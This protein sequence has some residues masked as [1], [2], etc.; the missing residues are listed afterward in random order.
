MLYLRSLGVLVLE[1][2]LVLGFGGH[3]A[4]ADLHSEAKAG[5]LEGVRKALEAGANPNELPEKT[6]AALHAAAL[7]GHKQIA[8][9][10]IEHGAK[11][12]LRQFGVIPLNLAVDRGDVALVTV[13]LKAGS[14]VES[15]DNTSAHPLHKASEMGNRPLVEILLA[16]GAALEAM[17]RYGRSPLAVAVSEG[18]VLVVRLLLARKANVD[19]PLK[20]GRRPLHISLRKGHA[21]ITPLLLE[22]GAKQDVL[23]AAALGDTLLLDALLT[24]GA[25]IEQPMPW[26]GT[27]PLMWA[28]RAGQAKTVQHLLAKG[29]RKNTRDKRSFTALHYAASSG[30]VNTARVLLDAGCETDAKGRF[31]STPLIEASQAGHGPMIALLFSR[32]ADVNAVHTREKLSALYEAAHKGHTRAVGALLQAKADAKRKTGEGSTTLHA[33]VAHAAVLEQL[34]DAGVPPDLTDGR[35]R[36]SLHEAAQEAHEESARLLITRGANVSAR[37]ARKQTPLHAVA[38]KSFGSSLFDAWDDGAAAKPTD[39][40]ELRVRAAIAAALLAAGADPTSEDSRGMTPLKLAREH[41]FG[42]VV[43]LLEKALKK[44]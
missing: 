1:M 23:T 3:L 16:H 24:Q 15:R 9:L 19:A 17:D 2:G 11:V 14:S 36:T 30:E 39:E 27:T 12:N 21:A 25:S 13:L 4:W 28:A 37:D 33:S 26:S 41:G 7:H 31:A 38:S 43:A 42:A 44:R 5:S 34:L 10:L 32:G 18:H 40:A 20:D 29:A 6:W 35:G 22:R 8:V